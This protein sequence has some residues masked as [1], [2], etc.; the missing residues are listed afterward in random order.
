MQGLSP[1]W[2]LVMAVRFK[3]RGL[4]CHCSHVAFVFLG[5]VEGPR[6]GNLL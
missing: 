4:G 5:I 3:D 2:C 6:F 1:T